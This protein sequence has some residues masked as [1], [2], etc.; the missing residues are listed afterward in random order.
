MVGGVCLAP[1]QWARVISRTREETV[2]GT[3]MQCPSNRALG[4]PVLLG[5]SFCGGGPAVGV[6]RAAAQPLV[7]LSGPSPSAPQ[8]PDL[9]SRGR[10]IGSC[11]R[12]LHSVLCVWPWVSCLCSTSHSHRS[13]KWAEQARADHPVVSYSPETPKPVVLTR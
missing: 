1:L 7:G 12:P 4:A 10:L 11:S 5:F 13:V 8:P 9:T 2:V 3:G 6:A